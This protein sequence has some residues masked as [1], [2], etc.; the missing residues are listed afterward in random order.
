MKEYDTLR[1]EILQNQSLIVQYD[2]V[3]YTAVAA[4]LVFALEHDNY[5][6]FLIP[7]LM[8]FFLEEKRKAIH[9]ISAYMCVFFKST[10]YPWESRLHQYQQDY[11]S[12]ASRFF[13][14]LHYHF[15]VFMCGM[16]SIFEI[17]SYGY[18]PFGTRIRIAS[19]GVLTIVV[20]CLM[21]FHTIDRATARQRYMKRWKI[22]KDREKPNKL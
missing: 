2:C 7:M 10:D 1:N 14:H 18:S 22:I 19:V 4:I 11:D 21:A 6:L 12:E 3:L 16:L 5:L 9:I 13:P 20:I 8:I 17:S 15:T